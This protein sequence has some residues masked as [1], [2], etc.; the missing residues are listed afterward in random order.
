MAISTLVKT[1]LHNSVADSVYRELTSKSERYYYFVGGVLDWSTPTSPPS[2][3]DNIQYEN[4]TRQNIILTKEIQ[5]SDIS[6]IVDRIDWV[7]GTV[8]DKY[9]DRYSNQVI[10]VDL[11]RKSTRLN[12]SH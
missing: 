4:T 9:D 6:Y 11:D 8:Y 5:P 1:L 3:I 12:S 7:S 10:G 2:P